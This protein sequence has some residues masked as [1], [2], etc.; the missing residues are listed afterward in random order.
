MWAG[1][2]D[3]ESTLPELL[4]R[5]VHATID[6]PDRVA[7]PSGES[8]YTGGW[9]GIALTPVGNECV[10]DGWSGWELSKRG[11]T[12]T[13]A[14]DDYEKRTADPQHLDP[15][16]TVFVFVTPRRWNGK[17]DWVAEKKAMGTWS[18]VRAYD[19]DDLEQWLE[20]APAVG[21][22]L[23]RILRKY[24]N[25][26]LSIDDYWAEY[27]LGTNPHFTVD[28]VLAGRRPDAERIGQWLQRGTGTLSVIADSPREAFAVMA[29]SIT[30]L[31][32]DE[33]AHVRSRFLLAED[34]T[35]LRELITT[36][37][38]LTV[39][40]LSTDTASVG[41]AV[42]QGH[43]VV[44][45]VRADQTRTDSLT[46]SRPDPEALIVALKNAGVTE[47]QAKILVR[48]TGRSITV[49]HRRLSTVPA[50]PAWATPEH[51]RELVPALLGSAW[52]EQH[53][54]DQKILASLTG[55]DYATLAA[56]LTK[57][58]NVHDAP[59][60][61]TG[62]V[63]TIRAPRD[64]W[65]LLH[66]QLT[67]NDLERFETAITNV[68]GTDDPALDLP[69]EE[70]WMAN[71]LGKTLPHSH[72]L[73]EGLAQTLVLIALTPAM[74]GRRGSDVAQSI[75]HRVLGNAPG[76]RRWYSA[77]SVLPLLAEAAPTAFLT[78]L[79][80]E[81]DQDEH[82]L[83]PLFEKQG[84]FHGDHATGLFRALELLAWY[85]EYLSR[86]TLLL[87]RIAHTQPEQAQ[88]ILRAIYL[89]WLPQT[90]A[91]VNDRTAALSVLLDREPPTGWRLVI[92]LWPQSYDV[93]AYHYAP[94]W[95][96][97]PPTTPV[98][99][100]ERLTATT[101]IID[102]ALGAA[103]NDPERLADLI[104]H[105]RTAPPPA[106]NRLREHLTAFTEAVHNPAA[107]SR[108]WSVLRDKTNEHRKFRDAQWALPETEL[109]L[110]D[111]IINQLTPD[112][113]IDRHAW[114]FN[115]HYPTLPLPD[116]N[117]TLT[118]VALEERRSQAAQEVLNEQGTEGVTRLAAAVEFPFL[119][120]RVCAAATRERH[121]TEFL[122]MIESAAE[123]TRLCGMGFAEQR[124]QQKGF[125]WVDETLA[126]H[127]WDAAATASF[128]LALPSTRPT[129]ERVEH[130]GVVDEYWRRTRPYLT[131]DTA[132]DDVD[133][134]LQH[135]LDDEQAAM[136]LD[137]AS[138]IATQVGTTVI[139]QALDA[140]LTGDLAQ[141]RGVHLGFRIERLLDAL[142]HRPDVTVNTIARYEWAF[143]P[144]LQQEGQRRLRL[145]DHL[146]TDPDLFA[147]MI[148]SVYPPEDEAVSDTAPDDVVAR[149][150]HAY[151]LLSSWHTIPGTRPD[152]TI[153]QEDLFTWSDRARTACKGRGDP[154]D[155]HIGQVLAHYAPTGTDG[156]WPHESVRSLIEHIN[157]RA[158]E[159]GFRTGVLNRPGFTTRDPFAGGA[160]EQT[161]ATQFRTWALR[162]ATSHRTA[163][164]LGEI[165]D[166]YERDAHREDIRAAQLDLR[167]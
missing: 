8:V 150:R 133:Y 85:P 76:S 25:G 39:G 126:A 111:P 22:W 165:A 105:I 118:D 33:Q 74:A 94:R 70:R 11:D 10:P 142:D 114:L 6:A 81:L 19:A 46:V 164:T 108:V 73:Q 60:Q 159:N 9:D 116:A 103:D 65:H 13:K 120:G 123:A 87:A 45:P 34:P 55:T 101:A 148:A 152:G 151:D 107:R 155:T 146:A 157:S 89:P 95:R 153:S 80:Q 104:T 1:R 3:C 17:E 129:W 79:E 147:Q 77:E 43:R 99:V 136:A 20:R 131:R 47:D 4:R 109:S 125:P 75:V 134:A 110:F 16:Q 106:R 128:L 143:L 97:K 141:F 71:V 156:I 161:L 56:N 137:L 138:M 52:D 26:V 59:V 121:E 145:H 124:H 91:P 122:T 27:S 102:L 144:L 41:V 140:A 35:V 135:L 113:I 68:L 83:D 30:V 31:S 37:N 92:Q 28:I 32:P 44:L 112:S 115:D 36:G 51:A 127:D 12:K 149:A 158:L 72:W 162:L 21:A 98:T 48:E 130:L 163:A 78:A 139:T 57:W 50:P 63:W 5:L 15:T 167:R 54:D 90:N 119:V 154:C 84:P 2:R 42:Q 24:P 69:A 67:R 38:S 62:T 58:S 86:V 53:D 49:L 7:F 82:R 66:N 64:A 132:N 100:A 18:D 117:L 61:Q 93:G 40:W 166:D 29:A 96:D 23:A 160:Q 14:D 88:R